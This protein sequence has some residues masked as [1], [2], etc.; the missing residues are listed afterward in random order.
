MSKNSWFRFYNDVLNDPKV[1]LLPK[2]LRWS[3]VE[4]LCLASKHDGILPSVEQIAFC[5]RASVNDA[6][7]DLDAL[8]F[9]GLI[10]I[11]PDGR[12]T[13]HNWSERQFASDSSRERT[14][15]YR[16]RMKKRC[17]DDSVTSQVTAQE[18]ETDPESDVNHYPSSLDAERKSEVSKSKDSAV[19]VVVEAEARRAVCRNLGIGNADPLVAI[20]VDWDGS[21]VD[22]NGRRVLN[23]SGKFIRWARAAY[24]RA[25]ADV[26][27]ACQPLEVV[28]TEAL[29][30][31]SVSPQLAAKL[32]MGARR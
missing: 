6:Q 22:E 18:T 29:P 20:F 13:P 23:P 2:A 1:Q 12:L 27:A 17:S 21:R 10:D 31:V 5:V 25:P 28:A 14:R 30:A 9:A 19:A 8:I 32:R 24:E 4:L 3:W 26:R 15:N 16:E 7:A 11:T